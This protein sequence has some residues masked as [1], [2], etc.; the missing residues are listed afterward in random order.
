[1]VQDFVVRVAVNALIHAAVE[2]IR[3]ADIELPEVFGFPGRERLGV[4]GFDVRIGEQAKHFQKFRAADAF[5]KL[6][7]C[8]R[9]KNIAPQPCS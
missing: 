5:R 3:R 8:A 7:D 9:I 4:D 6:R 2:I 1:M